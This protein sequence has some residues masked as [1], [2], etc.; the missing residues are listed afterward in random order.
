MRREVLDPNAKHS[1]IRDALW[2]LLPTVGFSAIWAA[3]ASQNRD[4]GTVITDQTVTVLAALMAIASV[5]VT[6]YSLA[7]ILTYVYKEGLL[8]KTFD[9][10]ADKT[11]DHEQR[12]YAT[13]A[14]IFKRHQLY[15]KR[16]LAVLAYIPFVYGGLLGLAA[17]TSP[18]PWLRV[19]AVFLVL[20][21]LAYCSRAVVSSFRASE[22]LREIER[23]LIK[24]RSKAVAV[25]GN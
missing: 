5:F 7:N 4:W 16:E 6:Q 11:A 10:I 8:V 23:I 15:L 2:S 1:I 3:V 12:L 20:W 17:I 13:Y 24:A 22:D 25:S 19:G 9:E 18:W 14:D 21:G